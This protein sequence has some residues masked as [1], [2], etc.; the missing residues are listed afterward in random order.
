MNNSTKYLQ[1]E[2][3]PHRSV[4]LRN[5]IVIDVLLRDVKKY[6][7]LTNGLFLIIL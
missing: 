5:V 3:F 2:I 6:I 7:S 4:I 1:L